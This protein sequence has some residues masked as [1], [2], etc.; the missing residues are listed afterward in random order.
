MARLA[1]IDGLAGARQVGVDG[2]TP[3]MESLLRDTFPRAALVDGQSLM[4]GVR[5]HKLP[6]EIDAIERATAVATAALDDVIAG[7]HTEVSERD[8]VARFE[9]R[10][11]E[12][13][14]TTPSF[15]GTFGHRFPS[16]RVL[17]AGERVPIDVGVLVDGYEGGLGRT[18]IAGD[19]LA[20]GT[21]AD[22]LLDALVA[23]VRPGATGADL[24]RVWDESGAPRPDG[25]I[26]HGIGLGL[27]P[28]FIGDDR[29]PFTPTMVLSIGVDVEGWVRRDVVLVTDDGA[30]LVQHSRRVTE[31]EG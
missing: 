24:W 29:T 25:P 10:M 5:R 8:L 26:A 12:L 7:A 31:E 16:D 3:L 6:E 1:T 19:G 20:S 15:E 17:T 27:E 18:L 30:E 23:A 11:C 9:Q 2:L 28:P 14:T 13:G 21:P 4:L 22:D